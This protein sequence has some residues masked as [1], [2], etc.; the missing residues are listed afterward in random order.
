MNKLI[1]LY[2][3]LSLSS[4]CS[5]KKEE[6][7]LTTQ[8]D[9]RYGRAVNLESRST[10]TSLAVA[11]NIYLDLWETTGKRIYIDAVDRCRAKIDEKSQ[12]SA[13]SGY[14]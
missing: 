10:Q 8:E 7:N 6:T 12:G 4:F 13:F 11:Y 9:L 1:P 2:L 5:D 3:L 14:Q